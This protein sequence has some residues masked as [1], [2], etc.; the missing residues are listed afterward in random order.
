MPRCAHGYLEN[1]QGA[2]MAEAQVEDDVRK[3]QWGQFVKGPLSI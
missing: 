2:M 1:R 3:G